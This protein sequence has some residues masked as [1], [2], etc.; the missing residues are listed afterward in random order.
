LSE[1]EIT[2]LAEFLGMSEHE[3]IQKHTRLRA[4]RRGLSL[5]E[6]PNGECEFLEGNDCRVQPVK[7]QQCRDF[8]N[9]WNFPGW[10]EICRA[11]SH[12]VSAEEYWERLRAAPKRV[13]SCGYCE[14]GS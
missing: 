12:E 10:R 14:R 6:K 5:L 2:R 3:F 11:I 8:P 9:L 1:E 13:K 4:D 7:P